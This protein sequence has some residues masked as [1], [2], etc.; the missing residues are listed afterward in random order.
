MGSG[1][2]TGSCTVFVNLVGNALDHGRGQVTVRV[3]GQDQ[4]VTTEVINQGPVIAPEEI[5]RLFEP[6]HHGPGGARALAWA[7]S[8][9]AR[10]PR[11]TAPRSRSPPRPRRA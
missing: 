11:P 6:F 10:S 5:S 2:A 1:T 4:Q 3:S 9:S 7:S 8:S